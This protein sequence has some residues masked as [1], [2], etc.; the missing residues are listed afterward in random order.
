MDDWEDTLTSDFYDVE[1]SILEQPAS[2]NTSPVEPVG[3]NAQPVH[4]MPGESVLQEAAVGHEDLTASGN[5]TI[6]L[7]GGVSQDLACNSAAP[8]EPKVCVTK[9][10]FNGSKTKANYDLSSPQ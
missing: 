8:D 3:G 5:N 7:D 6:I 4:E 1:E 10:S 9:I 2:S